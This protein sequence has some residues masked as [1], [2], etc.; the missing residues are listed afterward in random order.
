MELNQMFTKELTQAGHVRRFSI[1]EAARGGG[2]EV[3]EE[4]DSEVVRRVCYDDWHRVE[5]AL[6]SMRAQVL[7]LEERGWRPR[8]VSH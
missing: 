6:H 5:R 8:D 1:R 3:R 4:Q 7:E 2:W